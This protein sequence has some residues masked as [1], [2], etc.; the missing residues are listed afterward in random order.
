VLINGLMTAVSTK[1]EMATSSLAGTLSNFSRGKGAAAQP[2]KQPKQLDQ[3][4][5][6][7]ITGM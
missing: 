4:A 2:D 6:D 3:M 1:A 5:K 7:A